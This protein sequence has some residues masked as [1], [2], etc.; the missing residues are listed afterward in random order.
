MNITKKMF[1]PIFII[2]IL[3]VAFLAGDY[4]MTNTKERSKIYKKSIEKYLNFFNDEYK[5]RKDFALTNSIMLSKNEFVVSGLLDGEREEPLKGLKK[6]LSVFSQN[7]KYKHLKIHIHD[8]SLHSFLRVWKPKKFGD[9]LSSFRKTIVAV[10]K[11]KKPVVAI[12][13]GRAGMVLRG[14]AP[15]IEQGTYV[16]SVEIMQGFNSIVSDGNHDNLNV[17]ILLKKQYLKIATL[18][19]KSKSFGNYALAVNQ[20]NINMNFYNELK[21]LDLTKTKTQ[22]ANCGLCSCGSK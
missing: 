4:Y 20:K 7:T 22:W 1:I 3:F 8:D 5:A 15:V 18:L 13:L 16:G 12:E 19:K 10:K 2:W 21:N 14:V 9:D 17:V 6:I 11:T